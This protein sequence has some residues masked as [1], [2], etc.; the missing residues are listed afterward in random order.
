MV[1]N[2]VANPLNI[3]FLQQ[4]DIITLA[5]PLSS[6]QEGLHGL[7]QLSLFHYVPVPSEV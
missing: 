3:Q 5:Q 1:G 6:A 2:F 4:Q 7:K